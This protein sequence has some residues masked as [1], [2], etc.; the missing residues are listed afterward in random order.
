MFGVPTTLGARTS[1]EAATSE[2]PAVKPE[3][4]EVAALEPE[5]LPAAK[6]TTLNP[7]PLDTTNAKVVSPLTITKATGTGLIA[8]LIL[9]LTYDSIMVSKKNLPRKV[10]NNWAHIGFL[11]IVILIIVAMTQGKVI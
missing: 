5:V 10:G 9:V 8:L 3:V 4:I 11:G 6:E 7:T 1:K 2:A